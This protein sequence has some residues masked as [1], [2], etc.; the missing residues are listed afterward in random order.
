VVDAD[1]IAPRRSRWRGIDPVA[2]ADRFADPPETV[3]G[4]HVA[5]VRET[6]EEAGLLL[7]TGTVARPA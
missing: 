3:L 1:R 2:L 7:A 6:F 5:A 4:Y